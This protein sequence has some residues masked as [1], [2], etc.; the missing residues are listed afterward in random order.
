MKR[1]MSEQRFVAIKLPNQQTLGSVF[2]LVFGAVMM[3]GAVVTLL[4]LSD[5]KGG[6]LG[7]AFGLVLGIGLI[8][9]G[10]YWLL[11]KQLIVLDGEND[12]VCLYPSGR[13]WRLDQIECVNVW[14]HK[15]V[16][17]NRLRWRGTTHTLYSIYLAHPSGQESL[18]FESSRWEQV[19]VLAQQI[20]EL[21][22]KP[23]VG[24]RKARRPA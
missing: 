24:G 21:I 3:G 18:L 1:T 8:C 6:W 20:S 4:M 12:R 13:E 11:Q 23:W 22:G 9:S 19:R 16:D 15:G 17:P 10:V 14:R 7:P 2:A 5:E